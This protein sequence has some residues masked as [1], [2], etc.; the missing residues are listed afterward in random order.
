MIREIK[1][2]A[3]A[4]GS[5]AKVSV[6]GQV[7]G[8]GNV[9]KHVSQKVQ[10]AE[11]NANNNIT[12]EVVSE[13][14]SSKSTYVLHIFR[15]KDQADLPSH[16]A[17][18]TA[19]DVDFDGKKKSDGILPEFDPEVL[20]YSAKVPHNARSVSV[21]L[22]AIWPIGRYP[23][24]EEWIRESVKTTA[25]ARVDTYKAVIVLTP[26]DPGSAIEFN[27]EEFHFDEHG[28]KTKEYEIDMTTEIRQ[29]FTV[30]LVAPSGVHRTYTVEV[31]KNPGD[32]EKAINSTVNSRINEFKNLLPNRYKEEYGSEIEE[33]V[34]QSIRR[35]KMAPKPWLP[36]LGV[37]GK[38]IK[39]ESPT[40]RKERVDRM[41]ENALKV[42]KI[43]DTL[44]SNSATDIVE[45]IISNS[46][47]LRDSPRRSEEDKE[48]EALIAK[49]VKGDDS[50]QRKIG[51][52]SQEQRDVGERRNIASQSDVKRRKLHA[53]STRVQSM[54]K[55]YDSITQLSEKINSEGYMDNVGRAR[56]ALSRCLRLI[57]KCDADPVK[58]ARLLMKLQARNVLHKQVKCL[59]SKYDVPVM[60]KGRQARNRRNTC[61]II[62]GN[63]ET[64]IIERSNNTKA[65]TLPGWLSEL[66]KAK[67]RYESCAVV[68]NSPKLLESEHSGGAIDSHDA[69]FRLNR[70]PTRFY[71][72]Y[73]GNTTTFRVLG[74]RAAAMLADEGVFQGMRQASPGEGWVFWHYDTLSQEVD[75]KEKSVLEKIYAK[76]GKTPSYFVLSPEMINW[77]LQVY[78]AYMK[79]ATALGLA[80]RSP[81]SINKFIFRKPEL[82]STGMHAILLAHQ[83]CD[84]VNL[85][86]F[87]INP[88][89]ILTDYGTYFQIPKEPAPKQKKKKRFA[90]KKTQEASRKHS[91][92]FETQLIRLLHLSR[93]AFVCAY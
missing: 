34:Q 66:R 3:E 48:I 61:G 5:G 25:Q 51:L 55:M 32:Q 20:S 67:V 37:K 42:S 17:F 69:V 54:G 73:V 85:F 40:E 21:V 53:S 43:D 14:S 75:S 19:I 72:Q 70:A 89:E 84:K 58:T 91:W 49:L 86:G 44:S 38:A 63:I 76:F 77:Q 82:L 29:D 23:P 83:L 9:G 78:F 93:E 79:E 68:G 31:F 8:Y 15:R 56:N 18:L 88:Y 57:R 10:L 35:C 28:S 2:S 80:P 60:L 47:F 7:I 30:R 46:T 1:V 12:V 27:G 81:Y 65:Y 24:S 39:E 92:H 87:S 26:M 4:L 62:E 64:G 45:D 13:Q 59:S 74:L 50:N 16:L 71:E 6:D 22:L 90:P 36:L 33:V 11:V 41:V 52:E